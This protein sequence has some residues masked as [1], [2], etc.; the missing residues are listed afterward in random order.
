MANEFY[1]ALG[2]ASQVRLA[3]TRGLNLLYLRLVH[4]RTF[5]LVR[6]IVFKARNVFGKPLEKAADRRP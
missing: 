5:Q 6:E 1:G 3:P 2:V 4:Y